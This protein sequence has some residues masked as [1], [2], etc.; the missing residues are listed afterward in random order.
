VSDRIRQFLAFDSLQ[1]DILEALFRFGLA[2]TIKNISLFKFLKT[3]QRIHQFCKTY[4]PLALVI[5]SIVFG[6]Q[7]ATKE[8][9]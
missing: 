4:L 7:F 8:Y 3:S 1:I 5:I 6:I 2:Q 9:T